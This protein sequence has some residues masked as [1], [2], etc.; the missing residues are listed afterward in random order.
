MGFKT[1]PN[2]PNKEILSFLTLLSKQKNIIVLAAA[3]SPRAN[4][5][6]P[7]ALKVLTSEPAPLNFDV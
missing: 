3:Y 1:H 5:Q 6:V 2:K 4:A 7:S